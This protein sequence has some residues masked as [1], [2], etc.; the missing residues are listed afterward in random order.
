MAQGEETHRR[1]DQARCSE[2][3]RNSYR[4]EQE[5]LLASYEDSVNELRL[6]Q[7]VSSKAEAYF[8]TNT[9]DWDSLSGYGVLS[10]PKDDFSET[11]RADPHA[12]S[13]GKVRLITAPYPIRLSFPNKLSA[14]AILVNS[15][16]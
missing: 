5:G 3:S 13:C 7:R 12:G 11:P 2:V 6:R 10:L 4:I 9:V 15:R 1:A 8:D 16:L 14:D